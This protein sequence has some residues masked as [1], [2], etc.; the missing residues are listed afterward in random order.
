MH[1]SYSG[2]VG[3]AAEII[4]LFPNGCRVRLDGQVKLVAKPRDV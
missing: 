4:P 3:S 1:D 2:F